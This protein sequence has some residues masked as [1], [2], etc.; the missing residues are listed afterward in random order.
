[1]IRLAETY[2]TSVGV[3][4]DPSKAYAWYQVAMNNGVN[5]PKAIPNRIASQFSEE[6]LTEAN[7][8]IANLKWKLSIKE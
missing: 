7:K 8:L 4:K 5:L 1:M 6:Q 2:S 3:E